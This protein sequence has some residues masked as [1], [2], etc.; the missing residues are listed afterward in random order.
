MWGHDLEIPGV[1]T[2]RCRNVNF[3][4]FWILINCLQ[5]DSW[6]KKGPTRTHALYVN[7]VSA[8]EDLELAVG[9]EVEFL[10]GVCIRRFAASGWN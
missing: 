3:F 10:S 7:S 1:N 9:I 5:L 2:I 4:H 6:K 8:L